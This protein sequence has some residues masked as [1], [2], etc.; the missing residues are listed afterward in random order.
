MFYWVACGQ[1]ACCIASLAFTTYHDVAPQVKD[2]GHSALA[3]ISTFVPH[4]LTIALVSAALAFGEKVPLIIET[5]YA[6][7]MFI[8]ATLIP[9]TIWPDANPQCKVWN[10]WHCLTRND[11]LPSGHMI[12]ALSAALTLPQPAL[13]VAGVTGVTLVASRMHFSVDVVLSCWLVY[14]LHR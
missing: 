14:L 12:T 5:V 11:M 2:Y 8:K 4:S 9:L 10:V 13:F 1:I 7:A 3:K 6:P